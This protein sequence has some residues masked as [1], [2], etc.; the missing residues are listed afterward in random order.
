M[1]KK[2]DS[3]DYIAEEHSYAKVK[4]GFSGVGIQTCGILGGLEA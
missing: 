4:K 3:F 1:Q 2:I